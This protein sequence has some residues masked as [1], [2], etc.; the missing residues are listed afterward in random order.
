MKNQV[1]LR[2]RDTRG[3]FTLIES[4]IAIGV[5]AIL[6]TTFLAV[7]G[8]ASQ[9]IRRSI[10]VQEADR[11]QSALERE[12]QILREGPDDKFQTAFEKSVTGKN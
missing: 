8:P 11:L 9:S 12:F 5:V 3:G 10:S 7:F 4:V 6:L 1:G 2:R